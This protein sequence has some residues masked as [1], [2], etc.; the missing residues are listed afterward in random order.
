M[1]G[2]LDF[3]GGIPSLPDYLG[4]VNVRCCRW[5]HFTAT[6]SILAR[7]CCRWQEKTATGGR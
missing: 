3:A 7:F 6:G 4:G 5:R 2:F 1:D